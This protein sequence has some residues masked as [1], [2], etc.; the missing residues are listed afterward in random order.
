LD[1]TKGKPEMQCFIRRFE[2][3]KRSKPLDTLKIG[4]LS[5]VVNELPCLMLIHTGQSKRGIFTS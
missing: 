5:K 4:A 1:D 2:N 3:E